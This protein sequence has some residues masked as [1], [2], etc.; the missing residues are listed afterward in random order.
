MGTKKHSPAAGAGNP[1]NGNTDVLPPGKGRLL[2][3]LEAVWEVDCI[4]EQLVDEAQ[5][6]D[7]ADLARRGQAIRLRALA[8]IIHEALADD[9]VQPA[10]LRSELTG[11]PQEEVAHG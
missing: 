9:A 10:R 11:Q 7:V 3:A 1:E 6:L 8:R 2:L 5:N 4:A